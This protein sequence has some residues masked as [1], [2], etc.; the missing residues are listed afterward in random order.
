[1]CLK[2]HLCS[3]TLIFVDIIADTVSIIT[4]QRLF[5]S[6]ILNIK[7]IYNRETLPLR[8]PVNMNLF[9]LFFSNAGSQ[10]T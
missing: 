3:N 10:A 6:P 9:P 2:I 8:A 1:M 7:L 5:I 4:Y